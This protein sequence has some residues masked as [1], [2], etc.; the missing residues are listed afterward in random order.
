MTHLSC[1][2]VAVNMELS[3]TVK[4]ANVIYAIVVMVIDAEQT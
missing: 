4:Y 1:T 3:I 2:F